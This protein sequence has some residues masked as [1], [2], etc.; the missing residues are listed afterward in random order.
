[1]FADSVINLRS[2]NQNVTYQ[3]M[4]EQVNN[5]VS[6]FN[7]NHSLNN[8]IQLSRKTILDIIPEIKYYL[9]L[10]FDQPS[11]FY[12]STNKLNFNIEKLNLKLH[13]NIIHDY[14]KD[15]VSCKFSLNN[16]DTPPELNAAMLLIDANQA[17]LL[18]VD[19][20]DDSSIIILFL[21]QPL[22]YWITEFP[23]VKCFYGNLKS[24]VIISPI[25]M[26]YLIYK[27]F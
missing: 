20:S 3:I 19:D 8:I 1:M 27:H 22:T 4:M 14:L 7:L 17:I 9:F 6:K 18:R 2:A 16:T 11:G 21:K 13:L 26:I 24:F 25:I 12:K 5:S 15:N 23:F 10:N